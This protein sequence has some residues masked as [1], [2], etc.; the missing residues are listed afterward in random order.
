MNV[1][2]ELV[3]PEVFDGWRIEMITGKG[4][5]GPDTTTAIGKKGDVEISAI[6]WTAPMAW[7][8]L[9]DMIRKRGGE[10]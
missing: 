10:I 1:S 4:A 8:T 7:A 6:A 3:I 2:D 5:Y 9:Q